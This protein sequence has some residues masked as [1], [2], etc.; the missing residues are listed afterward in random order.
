METTKTLIIDTQSKITENYH[1]L[2]IRGLSVY[3]I[4]TH[5]EL[6][7]ALYNFAPNVIIID[8]AEPE[9][10]RQLLYANIRSMSPAPI[11]VL[12]VIDEPDIVEKVLDHGA[13]D[14]LLKP[15]SPTLLTAR[16]K[17]LARRAYFTNSLY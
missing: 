12:S 11:L 17:A 2:E 9:Q 1:E 16:I 6:F 4:R 10:R 7:S 5:Q 13:D 3:V 14:Y 8:S 15:V